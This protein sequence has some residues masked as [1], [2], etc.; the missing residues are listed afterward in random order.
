VAL[1]VIEG[2]DRT[3][4]ST[5][6]D[7]VAT[8]LHQHTDHLSAV[9]HCEAPDAERAVDEYLAP[10][11]DYEPQGTHH[12]I[13]DRSFVGEAVWPALF[14]RLPALTPSEYSLL[15]AAYAMKGAVYVLCERDPEDLHDAF[16]EA[17]PPEP[18]PTALVP[19]A[20]ELFRVQ[21]RHIVDHGGVT[22]RYDQSDPELSADGVVAEALLR[23]KV[24]SAKN[25]DFEYLL[26]LH[27]RAA[28][29]AGLR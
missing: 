3:G 11:L 27:L 6:A 18:L 20:V 21:F 5:L 2:V 7:R 22:L 14:G 25:I 10:L 12:L 19:A 23:S 29:F 9:V 8:K 17:D 16:E 15:H 28:A 4:K 1:I 13:F 24:A 26:P